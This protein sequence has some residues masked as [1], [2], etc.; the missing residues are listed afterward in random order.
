MYPGPGF[1]LVDLDFGTDSD[2]D[3]D[4]G[5]DSD[6][7]LAALDFD[8]DLAALDFDKDLVALDFD[9][10]FA[11]CMVAGTAAGKKEMGW[12][13][14]AEFAV[15]DAACSNNFLKLRRST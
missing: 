2:F 13:G 7:D 6:M 14:K 5:L 15:K 4:W 1:P 12:P 11:G 8:K 10:D 9:M 3:M